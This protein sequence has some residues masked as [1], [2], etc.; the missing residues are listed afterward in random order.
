[1]KIELKNKLVKRILMIGLVIL[2]LF[3]LSKV[4][5]FVMMSKLFNAIENFR[6]EENRSYSVKT[7][8]D[9]DVVFEET[10]LLK[11][12]IM[13]Y[14]SKE[15]GLDLNYRW[16]NFQNNEK[17]SF[18][19]KNKEVY[20]NDMMLENKRLLYNL[21]SLID[22]TFRENVSKIFDI[23]HIILTK[24]NN[25]ICYKIATKNEIIIIDKDTYLPVYSSVRKIT[26]EDQKRTKIENTYEFKVGEVTD[27]EVALPD[28]SEY[29]IVE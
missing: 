7:M 10:T 18:N 12:D 16:R 3:I 20:K 26:S 2:L 17:Y 5:Q 24:Y 15:N 1:M 28:L 23:R 27:E 14:V 9:E 6:K 8:L 29:T 21:P 25:K 19:I 4:Y 22:Y 11:K 13:K